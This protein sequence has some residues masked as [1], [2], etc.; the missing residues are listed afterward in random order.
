MMRGDG[1]YLQMQ[2]A[3]TG[4]PRWTQIRRRPHEY[5]AIAD[6]ESEGGGEGG[7][8]EV[9][10]KAEGPLSSQSMVDLGTPEMA[11][12]ES[13]L[14]AS[15]MNSAYSAS[16][17]NLLSSSVEDA[18]PHLMKPERVTDQAFNLRKLRLLQHMY[19]DIDISEWPDLGAATPRDVAALNSAIRNSWLDS[20]DRRGATG[21]KVDIPKGWKVMTDEAGTPYY[22]HVPSGKT[23]YDKPTEEV[24]DLN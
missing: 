3:P 24:S 22:W 23:Q 7:G 14:D 20:E 19:E 6:P 15:K 9:E 16:Q 10:N 4:P 1:E 2:K 11:W 5:E 13:D 17:P 21:E 8:E 18:F 12:D